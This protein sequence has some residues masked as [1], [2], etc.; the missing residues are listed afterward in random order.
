MANFISI[1]EFEKLHSIAW[2]IAHHI[3]WRGDGRHFDRPSFLWRFEN[4]VLDD[5][6]VGGDGDDKETGDGARPPDDIDNAEADPARASGRCRTNWRT[7]PS[8]EESR[9]PSIFSLP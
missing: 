4:R 9:L 3:R 8:T 2:K 6:D 1:C 7:F 5:V